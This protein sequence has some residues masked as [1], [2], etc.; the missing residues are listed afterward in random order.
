MVLWFYGFFVVL[1]FRVKYGRH[2]VKHPTD[3]SII[4]FTFSFPFVA[5]TTKSIIFDIDPS[6]NNFNNTN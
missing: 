6:S 2:V 4:V 5:S 1:L 3:V